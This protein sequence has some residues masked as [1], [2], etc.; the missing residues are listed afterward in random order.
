MLKCEGEEISETKSEDVET[1]KWKWQDDIRT[2]KLVARCDATS[3]S[4]R[5]DQYIVIRRV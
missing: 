1:Q 3:F 4:D 2:W 5:T